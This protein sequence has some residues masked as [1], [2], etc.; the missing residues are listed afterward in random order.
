MKKS[1]RRDGHR[2][3]GPEPHPPSAPPNH[4]LM[5]RLFALDLRTLAVFRIALA[6]VLLADLAIR[7]TDLS[8][9]YTDGGMFPRNQIRFR[10]TSA[11]N[12][13]LHFLSGDAAVQWGLFLTAALAGA[14][15]LVG[16]RTRMAAV[17]SWILLVS[18]QHRVPPI[19]NAGDPLLRLLLMWGLF[20]PMGRAFSVDAWQASRRGEHSNQ[21]NVLSFAGAAV[22]LQMV[23]MY[24]TSAIFKSTPDWFRGQVIAGSLAHDLYAKPTSEWALPHSGLLS[25]MTWSVFLLEWV[26][27]LLLM[28]PWRTIRFR[29]W[30]AGALAAMHLT[31]EVF[32]HVG[33]F[34]WISV[35][36]LTL[37][38]APAFWHRSGG[39]SAA[40]TTHVPITAEGGGGFLREGVAAFLL[41]YTLGVNLAGL[42]SHVSGRPSS[43]GWKWMNLGVGLGQK[44][45]MFDQTPSKDGWYVV[46]GLR[47]DGAEIDLMQSGA[48]LS[49]DR[50]N[51]PAGM[52]PNHRWRKLFREMCYFDDFGYQVF[53][54]PVARYLRKEWNARHP[55][56]EAVTELELIFCEAKPGANL[57]EPP[58]KELL[59]RI[60]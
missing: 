28:C 3:R 41:L 13:S 32:M 2:P 44:W 22:Q 56:D 54:E 19:S 12:W 47:A 17:V 8:A 31:I 33:M 21:G 52:F 27:P 1:S 45:S 51:H 4:G 24:L 37:F 29:F 59:T 15:L 35:A 38:F 6:L 14:A 30:I 26:G 9:M 55:A 58:S 57:G 53:R 42:E 10:Y 34:S 5:H 23:L 43:M 20:L 50:P 16:Y 11:W 7:F 40:Q 60:R 49:W 48:P 18:V 36:G 25:A 46:R 39:S